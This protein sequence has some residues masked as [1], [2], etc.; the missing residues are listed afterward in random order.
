MVQA[1]KAFVFRYEGRGGLLGPVTQWRCG[2]PEDID[3]PITDLGFRPLEP[4]EGMDLTDT[5]RFQR[6]GLDDPDPHENDGAG[7]SSRP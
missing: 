3:S 7:N 5:A 1:V 6:W 2:G 4:A